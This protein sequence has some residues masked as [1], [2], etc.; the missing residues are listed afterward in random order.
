MGNLVLVWAWGKIIFLFSSAIIILFKIWQILSSYVL[1]IQAETRLQKS[2]EAETDTKLL[3]LFAELVW[4][5]NGRAGSH[6][7][8]KCI[9]LLFE[10]GFITKE[11]V[12][13]NAMKGKI[14]DICIVSLPVGLASQEAAIISLAELGKRYKILFEPAR[15]TLESLMEQLSN[16]SQ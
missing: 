16:K 12:A 10:K 6:V 1:K 7:S 14:G 5:A 11:D 3:K 9:E 8:D 2:S 4:T 15:V 13:S